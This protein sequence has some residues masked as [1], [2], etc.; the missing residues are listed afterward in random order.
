MVQ[1]KRTKYY[2]NMG[3]S[4]LKRAFFMEQL[5]I[6]FIT[7]SILSNSSLLKVNFLNDST[8]SSI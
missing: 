8:L 5:E 2:D 6:Y 1:L 7:S 3:K 4:A